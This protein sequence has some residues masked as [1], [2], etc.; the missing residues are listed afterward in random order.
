MSEDQSHY[1]EST[2]DEPRDNPGVE[3]DQTYPTP[4]P[5]EQT[6]YPPPPQAHEPYQYPSTPPPPLADEQRSRPGVNVDWQK[7]GQYASDYWQKVREQSGNY[8]RQSSDYLQQATQQVRGPN[9]DL[10]GTLVN[11]YKDFVAAV[12]FLSV[13]A[14]PGRERLFTTERADIVESTPFFGSTYFPIVGLIIAVLVS[15]LP[16]LLGG[17]LPG[18]VLGGLVV[19]AEVVLTGGLHLDGLMDTC[20]GFF[21]GNGRENKL[22]I[23]SDSRVGGFGVLGAVCVLLLKFAIYTSLV[24]LTRLGAGLLPVALITILPATRWAMVLAVRVFPSARPTGLGFVFRQTVTMPSLIIGGVISLL[25]ALIVG[26]LVG[27]FLW[28]G[29]A[30]TALGL[31]LWARRVLGG[32]TGDIYGTIAEVTEVVALI[33]LVLLRFL[34]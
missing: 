7:A 31:G 12:R 4:L 14:L 15:I 25:I 2:P 17:Y 18:I 20:D 11:Q 30:L 21:G 8:W 27:F 34:I 32:L 10:R 26:H 19:V 33:L 23:M 1:E 6:N 5:D 9:T 29:I 22:D 24:G 28:I 13:I 16:W 3:P